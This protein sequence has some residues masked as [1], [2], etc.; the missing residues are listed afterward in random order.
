M[1][2]VAKT[3][4]ANA[5]R[6][7]RFAIG[8]V[9]NQSRAKQRR[10]LDVVIT[11]RQMETISR[12]REGELGV[13]AIE[14]VT[15]EARVITKIFSV[16]S[17]IRAFAISPAKPRDSDA[18]SDG[19]GG[20]GL[21]A[22]AVGTLRSLP[23]FTDFFDSSDNLVTE[24][25]RKLRIGQFTIDHVKIGAANRTGPDPHEQLSPARLGLRHI[26][27]LQR[28]F[29]FVQNHRMHALSINDE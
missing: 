15:G 28:P 12:I 17:A 5:P 26:A 8:A 19:E 3:I 23:Q 13:T 1:R 11:L 9:T 20:S 21:S 10:N 25:Q 6:I 29:R 14:R 22:G 16:R 27:Q 2:G 24:N 7:A 4:Q 18:I